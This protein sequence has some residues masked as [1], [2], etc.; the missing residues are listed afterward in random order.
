MSVVQK[1]NFL[2]EVF[3]LGKV[4]CVGMEFLAG[5]KAGSDAA[6][7]WSALIQ[8]LGVIYTSIR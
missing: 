4:G 5:Q 7:R 2:N 8:Q 6:C 1:Q 3:L